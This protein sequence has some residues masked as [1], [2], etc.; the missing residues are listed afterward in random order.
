MAVFD[1]VNVTLV[2]HEC[3]TQKETQDRTLKSCK[4]NDLVIDVVFCM[5]GY[6]RMLKI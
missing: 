4:K 1:S 2:Y 3:C 6:F 5:L